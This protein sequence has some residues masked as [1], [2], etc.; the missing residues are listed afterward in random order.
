MPICPGEAPR[1]QEV[2]P[3]KSGRTRRREAKGL[4]QTE[5]DA[6]AL[7]SG[8]AA[9]GMAS[10]AIHARLFSEIAVCERVASSVRRQREGRSRPKVESRNG[11]AGLT[12]AVSEGAATFAMA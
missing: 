7:I 12:A 5:K 8:L 3:E 11:M 2:C 6:V 10:V 9:I 1:R 4:V